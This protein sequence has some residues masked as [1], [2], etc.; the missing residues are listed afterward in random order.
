MK[1]NKIDEIRNVPPP[2]QDPIQLSE[3]ENVTE[4]SDQSLATTIPSDTIGV[5][6]GS[7]RIT[8]NE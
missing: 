4:D 3:F 2:S 5:W 8:P 1:L 7:E 6:E